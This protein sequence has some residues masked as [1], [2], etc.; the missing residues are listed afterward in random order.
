MST[1]HQADRPLLKARDLTQVKYIVGTGGALTR[2]PHRV[3]IMGDDPER[4]RNRHEA[5]SERSSQD[6]GR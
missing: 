4:Q 3:D 1:A 2:L 5:V 6:T